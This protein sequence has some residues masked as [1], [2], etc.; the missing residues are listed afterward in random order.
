MAVL[1]KL[2]LP[3]AIV[4]ALF[5]GITHLTR[6]VALV[7]T[8]ERGKAIMMVPASVTVQAE[9]ISPIVSE[10]GGRIKTEGYNLDPGL[11]VKAGEVLAHLDTTTLLL[12]M[13]RTSTDLES[14]RRRKE[15]G[16]PLEQDLRNA[17]DVLADFENKFRS[18]NL[19]ESE[20]N[21][22]R[23][24]V[25]QLQQRI[26]LEKAAEDQLI[27]SFENRLKTQ[28]VQLDAA[29]IK[30]RINGQIAEVFVNAEQFIGERTVVATM[31]TDSRTVEAKVSE[32]HYSDLK[33]GQ[34]ATVRFLG[35]GS[36][37]YGASITKILPT[38]DP[39]TQRYTVQ[40]NVDIDPARLAPGLTGEVSIIT[41]VR[42]NTLIIPRRALFGE[43]V[44]AVANGRVELRKVK[45]GF[46]SLYAVEVLS[47][48]EAGE[49]VIVDQLERYRVGDRVRT[50]TEVAPQS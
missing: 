46:T 32:E 3:L 7:A 42:E 18:G 23:R 41:G 9:N 5:F 47:G 8:V 1:K 21:K 14:A 31:I 12:E 38:A 33:V 11:R 13:E 48:L 6:P 20:L 28:Q 36:Q 43:S 15:I 4:V 40:L 27:A 37:E 45:L 2:V 17:Q 16:I 30:A 29:T 44:Y 24:A 34:Q 22:Q 50:Q 25:T 19:A 10:V 26:N 39:A 49:L 35:L